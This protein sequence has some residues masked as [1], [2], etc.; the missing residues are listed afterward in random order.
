MRITSSRHKLPL[1]IYLLFNA[2]ATSIT[3]SEWV[4]SRWKVGFW[5]W[6]I[7]LVLVSI[8]LGIGKRTLA[9]GERTPTTH[10]FTDEPS[11]AI[12]RFFA[13]WYDNAPHE[14]SVFCT[15]LE[16]IGKDTKTALEK[17]VRNR[18]GKL[19]LFLRTSRDT[20]AEL[21]RAQGAHI[22]YINDDS[23]FFPMRFS[24]KS[25]HDGNQSIICRDKKSANS[26]HITFIE[27]NNHD[28]PHLVGMAEQLL[29]FFQSNATPHA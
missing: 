6:I 20:T 14:L 27:T 9:L 15:D 4:T 2:I 28:S 26:S 18:P 1:V 13:Q 21:L 23:V 10:V 8:N 17:F 29:A 19:F 5:E 25:D 24:L 12:D 3:I 22:K 16:W 11:V 7:I